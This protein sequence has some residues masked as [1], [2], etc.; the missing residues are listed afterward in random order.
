MVAPVS[1]LGF[2]TVGLKKASRVRFLD[3]T[4]DVAIGLVL[5][6]TA[7]SDLKVDKLCESEFLYPTND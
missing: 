4:V 5:K 7:A 6:I 2:F 1:V 3:M